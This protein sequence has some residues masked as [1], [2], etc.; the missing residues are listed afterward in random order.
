MGHRGSTGGSGELTTDDTD[1]LDGSERGRGTNI[2]L[3]QK[4]T[5]RMER[6]EGEEINLART[7]F[8]SNLL[9]PQ[10]TKAKC[11]KDKN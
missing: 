4:A 10:R 7:G 1:F 11:T 5:E 6:A 2:N 8:V 3:L 9:R